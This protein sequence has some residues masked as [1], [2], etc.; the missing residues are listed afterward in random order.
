MKFL[1][2]C[3]A[4]TELQTRTPG[5]LLGKNCTPSDTE[6]LP[7]PAPPAAAA[8]GRDRRR[9]R[10]AARAQDKASESP[11]LRLRAAAM[12]MCRQACSTRSL[13]RLTSSR[14]GPARRRALA[15][16]Q[17]AGAQPPLMIMMSD[18][19]WDHR[20]SDNVTA[21]ESRIRRSPWSSGSGLPGTA[22]RRVIP[23][24]SVPARESRSESLAQASGPTRR[25]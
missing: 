5:K 11:P 21:S 20:H 22:R 1:G 7:G 18:S 3:K 25:Q 15:A 9:R 2:R 4:G 10:A 16:A 24:C 6:S 17:W 13:S 23:V 12:P 14:P 19:D 8:A